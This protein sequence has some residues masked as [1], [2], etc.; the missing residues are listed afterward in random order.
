MAVGSW[1][2]ANGNIFALTADGRWTITNGNGSGNWRYEANSYG[3]NEVVIT[4]DAGDWWPRAV[5][6]P[7]GLSLSGVGD[8]G[9]NADA[10]RP[11]S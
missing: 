5:I 8:D 6:A 7:D 4:P 11:S 3:D 10:E 2:R 9:Q 1:R